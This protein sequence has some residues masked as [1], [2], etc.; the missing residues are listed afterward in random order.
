MKKTYCLVTC[1][2]GK[3][4]SAELLDKHESVLDAAS[5]FSDWL[6]ECRKDCSLIPKEDVEE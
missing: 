1:P 4:K 3:Q 6:C 2:K 5:E